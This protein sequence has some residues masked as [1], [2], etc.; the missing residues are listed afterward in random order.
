MRSSFVEQHAAF[1]RGGGHEL[2]MDILREC[3]K[4]GVE[5]ELHVDLGAALSRIKEALV[6]F[7]LCRRPAWRR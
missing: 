2:L 6:R 5:D 7:T 1:L 4:E 3:G